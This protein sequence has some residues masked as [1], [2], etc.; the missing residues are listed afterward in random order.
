MRI[1]FLGTGEIALP[2]FRALL[3]SDHEV[4]ALVT[5]PDKAVGRSSK[6]QPPAI[7]VIAQE[8]DIPVL[9]PE[10]VRAPEALAELAALEAEVMV[11]MAYGQI[12]PQKLIDL[13]RKAIINLHASLLPEYRGASCIQ[14]AIQNG[15]AETGW[16]VMHVVKA[17]DAGDIIATHPTAIGRQETASELHDRLAEQGPEAL[18]SALEALQNDTATRTPQNES[19]TSYAPKLEREDGRLDW[20]QGA[21]EL[22]RLIR[23][24]H[25]WPGTFTTYRDGRGK[26]RRLKVFPPTEV[27]DAG[28]TPGEVLAHPDGLQIACGEGSLLLSQVQPEGSRRMSA[29]DF[30]RGVSLECLGEER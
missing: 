2:A 21:E 23:A 26:S 4:V 24:Y 11:V 15:D 9:Q 5:Q 22:E 8:A 18:L 12:L 30:G 14:A 6:L 17:L 25:T 27:L 10:K 16:T 1:V 13:P 28:G 29:T 7:K 3:E 19:A 20:S